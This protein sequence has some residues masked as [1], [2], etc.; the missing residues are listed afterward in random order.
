MQGQIN[1][2]TSELPGYKKKRMKRKSGKGEGRRKKVEEKKQKEEEEKNKENWVSFS[3]QD[4]CYLL[5]KPSLSQCSLVS[6]PYFS[7][8]IQKSF[9][10]AFLILTIHNATLF[11]ET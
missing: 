8:F 6:L 2:K 10:V 7:Q 4:N 11:S 5:I 1:P 3:Q 9:Q